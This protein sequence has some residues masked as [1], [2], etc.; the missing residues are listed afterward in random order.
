MLG[1]TSRVVVDLAALASNY[2]YLSARSDR[3]CAGVVKADGYGLGI[4]PVVTALL[5]E[6]CRDIF[7]ATL[8]EALH[9]R[10]LF[11]DLRIIALGG[12]QDASAAAAAAGANIEPVINCAAQAQLWVPYAQR[13][14]TL[15]V[16][17]GMQRLGCSAED[18]AAVDWQDF[19]IATLMTHLACADVPEHPMNQ[20]QLDR[21]EGV[22]RLFPGV[23]TSIANSAGCLLPA[24]WHGDLTR[25][26]IGLYGGHPQNRVGDNPLKPVAHMLGQIVS[27][28]TIESGTPVGYGGA[29]VAKRTT[30]LAVVGLGYADGLPR[31]VSPGVSGSS[32]VSWMGHRAPIVGRVSMDL[33]H[34]DVTDVLELATSSPEEGDWVEFLGSDIGVDEV[35]QWAGTIGLEILCGLGRRAHWE[36][37]HD[38]PG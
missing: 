28:R 33:T 5:A 34:V 8:A 14:V 18:L 12:I 10:T 4:E 38:E 6:G 37:R 7:V 1:N 25:P 11:A 24:A 15:H 23:P 29:F 20:R 17:T 21:F 32:H 36:Y 3:R 16:D 35:A 9:L 13:P 2:R 27:R 30:H 31:C 26:G 19:T 22:R